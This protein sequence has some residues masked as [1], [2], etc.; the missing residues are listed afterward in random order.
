M[1]TKTIVS[2]ILVVGLVLAGIAFLGG[3]MKNVEWVKGR[4]PVVATGENSSKV[5]EVDETFESFTDLEVNISMMSSI[6]LKEGDNFSVKGKN[7]ESNGGLQA[8][9]EGEKLVVSTS[10]GSNTTIVNLG[11]WGPGF[12]TKDCD[13][14]ITY[15]KGATLGSVVVDSDLSELEV[16]GLSAKDV[17]FK[18]D[19]GNIEAKSIKASTLDVKAALGKCDMT[20]VVVDE[21]IV[22]IDTGDLTM[23]KVTSK[24]FTSDAA[25]G[26][27][28][29]NDVSLGETDIDS[30]TGNVNGNGFKVTNLKLKVSLGN[31]DIKNAVIEGDG[32]INADTGDVNIDFAMNETDL[33]YE[34]ET[35]LG[36]INING[37]RI[38]G[39]ENSRNNN[40]KNNL[41]IM[42][43]LGNIRLGFR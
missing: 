1:K 27:T 12:T 28:E 4:G 30:D 16:D 26:E 31:V 6:T 39:S 24:K 8:K 38:K 42:V 32:K 15:P 10:V 41:E 2:I 7:Y 22:D 9:L 18:M 34:L 33:N 35:D 37:D 19:T 20:D 21:I 43:S 5:I 29:F 14:V 3:G 13:V 25:L 11:S 40:A 17:K 23:E 36:N